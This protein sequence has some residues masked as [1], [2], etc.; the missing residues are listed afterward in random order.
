MVI[1]AVLQIQLLSRH[2][3]ADTDGAGEAQ[4]GPRGAQH[5]SRRRHVDRA[6]PTKGPKPSTEL[7]H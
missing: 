6:R 4:A 7:M 5:S 2:Q 1:S 3:P